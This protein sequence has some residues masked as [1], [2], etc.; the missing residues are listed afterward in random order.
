MMDGKPVFGGGD[1]TTQEW[2]GLL[3]VTLGLKEMVK[4]LAA[5]EWASILQY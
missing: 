4:Y 2:L 3:M 5:E 1:E